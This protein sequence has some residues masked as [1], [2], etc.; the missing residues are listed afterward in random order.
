[1]SFV[2]DKAPVDV[3]T[4][5]TDC[6][7]CSEASDV[8]LSVNTVTAWKK[9]LSLAAHQTLSQKLLVECELCSRALDTHQGQPLAEE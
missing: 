7:A 5:G 1:M 4:M 8:A 3:V 6:E 9:Q 2:V